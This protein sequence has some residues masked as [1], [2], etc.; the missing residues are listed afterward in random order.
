MRMQT[1]VN[2]DPVNNSNYNSYNNSPMI[3]AQPGN[4]VVQGVDSQI[5]QCD[6]SQT[7][8]ILYAQNKSINMPQ[9]NVGSNSGGLQQ[10]V[11]A[12]SSNQTN[13]VSKYICV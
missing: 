10:V 12:I 3:R 7:R 8:Q 13:M 9:F 2:N 4:V 1:P 5:N 6:S 11:A